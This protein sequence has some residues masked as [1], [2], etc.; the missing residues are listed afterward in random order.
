M[1]ST[2]SRTRFMAPTLLTLWRIIAII[3]NGLKKKDVERLRRDGAGAVEKSR[4]ELCFE[5]Q[6]NSLYKGSCTVETMITS[7]DYAA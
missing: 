3:C 5:R 6:S 4:G 7:M 2:C 1:K